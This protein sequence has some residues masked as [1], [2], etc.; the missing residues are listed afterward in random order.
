MSLRSLACSLLI[1]L[2]ASAQPTPKFEAADVRAIPSTTQSESGPYLMAG[3][4]QVKRATLLDLIQAAYSLDEDKILGG[5][6]WLAW[7]HFDVTAKLPSG[8]TAETR[9][10]MLQELLAE[11]FAL[12]VHKDSQPMPAWALTAGKHAGLKPADANGEPG[13]KAPPQ[14]PRRVSADGTVTLPKTEYTCRNMTMKAFVEAMPD[15]RFAFGSLSGQPVVD[16]TGL[17]GAWDFSFQYSPPARGPAIDRSDAISFPEALDRQLG[18]KLEA[19]KTPLPVLVVDSANRTPAPNP[20]DTAAMLGSA[21]TE[22]E[23][24]EIKPAVPP[25]GRAPFPTILNGEFIGIGQ[26]FKNGRLMLNNYTLLGLIAAAWGIEREEALAAPKGLDSGRYDVIAKVPGEGPSTE[27]EFDLESVRPMLQKLLID[28]FKLAVHFE[29]R[30]LSSYALTAAKPKLQ[31]ADPTRRSKC[32]DPP[33]TSDPKDPRVANPALTRLLLCQNVTMAQFAEILPLQVGGYI[34]TAVSDATGLEGAYD[35]TLSFSAAGIIN[36]AKRIG[37]GDSADPSGG[38]SL[39]DA[40]TK[41]LGLKLEPQKRP[42]PVLV[43]D[44][45][46]LK[47]TDN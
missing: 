41:Q 1:A 9:K 35:F 39:F 28:R 13:C 26:E 38:L 45:V 24:A 7:D 36:G 4:Y 46:E 3:R 30:P 14:Q 27:E 43:I 37:G 8:S 6:A 20:P 44:R 16:Q 18:L 40:L 29:D 15:L 19:T 34:R 5:P 12:K 2:A 25:T 22:F 33:L 21:P 23:V 11:R 10:L 42:M 32:Q 17:S 31:P 47:P